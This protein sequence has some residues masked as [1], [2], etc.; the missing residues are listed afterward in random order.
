MPMPVRVH[1]SRS[2]YCNADRRARRPLW[3]AALVALLACVAH[4]VPAVGAPPATKVRLILQWVHQAQFAGYYV[5]FEQG[6]YQRRGLDV[7]ILRGGPGRTPEALLR[8][9]E[10]DVGTFFLTG[11][12]TALDRGV[13][14]VHLTQVVNRSNLMLV[15]WQ[16]AGIGGPSDLDGRRVSLWGDAFSAAFH[17]LFGALGITPTAVP[18]YWS[19]NLFLRRGVAACAAMYYNEYHA[20]ILAG[21]EPSELTP[22]FLRD[23]GF[24][25]PEDGIY[26]VDTFAREHPEVVQAFAE[27]SLEGWERAAELPDEALAT[28]M[29]WVR[30][31]HVPTSRNHMRWMLETIL[32]SIIPGRDDAWTLGAL[33]RSDYQRTVQALLAA[34]V[35]RGAPSFEAFHPDLADRQPFTSR[36]PVGQGR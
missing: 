13:P 26:C 11:A 7:E 18:Q 33:S 8:T 15:G 19:T 35:I 36:L 10:A 16:D 4:P 34:G 24:G 12:L 3:S 30:E 2:A 32:P 22:I 14:L 1:D 9:G 31:A 23:T 29:R 27:A 21:V 5:A 25:F 28:V 20:I 6:Y 17:G